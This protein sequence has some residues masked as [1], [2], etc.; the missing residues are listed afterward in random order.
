MQTFTQTQTAPVS[1]AALLRPANSYN[2]PAGYDSFSPNAT[3]PHGVV[4]YQTPLSVEQIARFDLLPLSG[5]GSIEQTRLDLSER[6]ANHEMRADCQ[7]EA[8]LMELVRGVALEMKSLPVY[9]AAISYL[10]TLDM[11]QITGA[12]STAPPVDENASFVDETDVSETETADEFADLTLCERAETETGILNYE[13]ERIILRVVFATLF[14][15]LLT[16]LNAKIRAH[17]VAIYRAQTTSNGVR[18][19]CYLST[20]HAVK[21]CWKLSAQTFI[22]IPEANWQNQGWQGPQ[23]FTHRVEYGVSVAK[24]GFEAVVLW[25]GNRAA[26]FRSKSFSTVAAA[27]KAAEKRAQSLREMAEFEGETAQIIAL[28]IPESLAKPAKTPKK[29]APKIAPELLEIAQKLA[30]WADKH[31]VDANAILNGE[32]PVTAPAIIQAVTQNAPL[33]A[34]QTETTEEKPMTETLQSKPAKPRVRFN[35][36]TQTLAPVVDERETIKAL[37]AAAIEANPQRAKKLEKSL[38][39]Q[40]AEYDATLAH[41][42]AKGKTP[43]ESVALWES[44]A[45]AACEAKIR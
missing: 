43:R 21:T 42:A 17:A 19:L 31:G 11:E 37:Y 24:T 27:Q 40:L 41:L 13:R 6:A 33:S 20:S 30:V 3:Y 10:S 12:L 4:T 2:V 5:I 45:R 18:T 8:D 36:A 32:T 1:Y 14:L 35:H 16:P 29:A 15:A 39:F 28:P 7:S 9:A 44:R 22:N 38:E 25:N 34:P 23:R 26:D